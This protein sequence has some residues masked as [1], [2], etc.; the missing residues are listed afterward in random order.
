MPFINRSKK[1]TELPDPAVDVDWKYYQHAGR[2]FLGAA[3]MMTPE[4]YDTQVRPY[5]KCGYGLFDTSK[6]DQQHF[7]RTLIQILEGHYNGNEYQIIDMERYNN[8]KENGD[9]SLPSVYIF[10]I[11]VE[12][13]D[14]T[15]KTAVELSR[16]I[17]GAT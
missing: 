9:N 8:G 2:P 7:G 6:P 10:V 17:R 13:F 5:G 12:N 15:Q 4:E 1:R 16:K 3:P 11:W 14:T